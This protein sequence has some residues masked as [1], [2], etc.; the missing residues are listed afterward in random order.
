MYYYTRR[1]IFTLV[2][3]INKKK[4]IHKVKCILRIGLIR[5]RNIKVKIKDIDYWDLLY[6]QYTVTTVFNNY[7]SENKITKSQ[8]KYKKMINLK[9]KTKSEI[10]NYNVINERNFSNIDLIYKL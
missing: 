8:K 2:E 5:P 10:D 3:V 7:L 9:R 4:T 6:R 1:F